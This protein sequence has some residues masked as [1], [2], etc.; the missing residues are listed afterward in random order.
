MPLVAVIPAVFAGVQ[1]AAGALTV[2]ET[3]A[4]IGTIA[5]AIGS[6]TGNKEL[7]QLGGVAALAGGVGMFA[8]NQGWIGGGIKP[9]NISPMISQSPD[10][11]AASD[12]L[13]A[14]TG[15]GVQSSAAGGILN[16][17]ASAG[18]LTSRAPS[19]GV[20]ASIGDF[21]S[22]N[23]ELTS[24]GLSLVG[25]AFD[26]KKKA[27]ADMA[28]AHAGYYDAQANQVNSQVRNAS[29]IPDITNLRV[30]QSANVYNTPPPPKYQGP[31]VGLLNRK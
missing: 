9:D 8:Q 17:A 22:K 28:R 7:A 1:I 31:T 20:M 10:M 30:N 14:E 5:G 13:R 19:A 3:V 6:L 16:E 12:A 29:A 24:M 21:M 23:K 15:G 27:D 18:P 11:S 26:D 25:G 4:A 2:I